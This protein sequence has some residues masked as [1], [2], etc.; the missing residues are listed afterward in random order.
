M[1]AGG[2]RAG[3]V[4]AQVVGVRPVG[5]DHEATVTRDRHNPAP[6][7]RLTEVAAIRGVCGVARVVQLVR[8]DLEHG[9]SNLLGNL[10]RRAPLAVRVRCAPPDDREHVVHAGGGARARRQIGRVDATAIADG[11][12]ALVAQPGD[13][14]LLFV[15]AETYWVEGS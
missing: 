15:H 6:Q 5:D 4:V 11:D 12:A 8:L 14:R 9:Q 1:F 2:L 3:P 7:L 10:A 13:E